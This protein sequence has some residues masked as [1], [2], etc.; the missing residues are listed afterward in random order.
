MHW[1][2]MRDAASVS[3]VHLA[4]WCGGASSRASI[5]TL[6]FCEVTLSALRTAPGENGFAY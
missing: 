4:L 1:K 3:G 2:P 5:C 6:P